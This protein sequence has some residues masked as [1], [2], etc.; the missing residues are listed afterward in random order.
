[1]LTTTDLPVDEI[2]SRVGFESGSALSRALRRQ[3]GLAATGIRTASSKSM[4]RSV[5]K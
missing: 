4:A 3:G 1:M 2:A 5:A